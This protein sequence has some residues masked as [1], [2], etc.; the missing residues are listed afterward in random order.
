MQRKPPGSSEEAKSYFKA[1]DTSTRESSAKNNLDFLRPHERLDKEALDLKNAPLLSL[2][3]VQGAPFGEC[4]ALSV[5]SLG[6]VTYHGCDA[7]APAPHRVV[8]ERTV[9]FGTHAASNDVILPECNDFG[10]QHF[11]VRYQ[12]EKKQYVVRDLGQGS[13]TFV[14]VATTTQ[15]YNG[16]FVFLV[17]A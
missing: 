8:K 15:I 14:Q 17:M 2:S 4:K 5:N 16:M 10:A 7:Q 13:G 9:Y 1:F 3:V 6:S 11:C 12:P